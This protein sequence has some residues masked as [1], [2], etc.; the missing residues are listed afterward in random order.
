MNLRVFAFLLLVVFVHA[1]KAIDVSS[2]AKNFENDRVVRT[3]DLCTSIVKEDIGIRANNTGP[4]ATNVYHFTI[5]MIHHNAMAS[6]DAYLKQKAKRRL[7]MEL[8]GFDQ[9]QYD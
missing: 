8:A 5:P 7:I 2:L 9:S 3:V 1:V 4:K 6:Y